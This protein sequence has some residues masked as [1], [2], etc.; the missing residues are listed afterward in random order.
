MVDGA[1]EPLRAPRPERPERPRP[2]EP[3]PWLT[4]LA[5]TGVTM[6]VTAVAVVVLAATLHETN[7][8]LPLVSN[9]VVTAGLLPSI[10]LARRTPVWRGVSGGV[11]AGIALS[12]LAL[13]FV[14]FA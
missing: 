5:V 9:V 4:G 7:P 6:V 14:L 2:T 8:L 13:P 3:V 10:W 1:A 12:W 11:A